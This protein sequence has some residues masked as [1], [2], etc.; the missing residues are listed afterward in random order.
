MENAKS[1]LKL[2]AS[3]LAA[4]E[5]SDL[6]RLTRELLEEYQQELAFACTC[7][8]RPLGLRTQAGRLAVVQGFTRY[9]HE[10]D[11][12]TH[13][14][15]AGLRLP[16]KPRRLPRAIL[17]E[18]EVATLL[19][20]P[21]PRNHTGYRNRIILELLYDTAI[22]RAEVAGIRL[23]DLDLAGGYLMIHGKGEKDRVVPVSGR[24]CALLKNYLL[25]VRP[26]YLKGV[27]PGYLVLNRW[28][29]RMTPS[30]VWAVVKRCV[31]LAHLEKQVSTHTL[32]HTCATHMLRNGAPIRHLQELLGHESLET[33]QIYTRV[34][35]TDLK[36]VH[37]KYHPS[38]RLADHKK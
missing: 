10:H 14:P 23:A 11:Y 24:L 3:F 34:T 22:R 12:L 20:A 36:A 26:A 31:G 28:G 4:E 25:G 33:T 30:A 2:F 18:P 7:H 15:G 6:S 13:D 8:G 35:I 38:E 32:R 19:A 21:D 1:G 5:A 9:L 17:S 27:D 29:T 37:A 16:R